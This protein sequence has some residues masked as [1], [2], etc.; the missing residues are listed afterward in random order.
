[1]SLDELSHHVAGARVELDAAYRAASTERAVEHLSRCAFHLR[2]ARPA[3]GSAESI[4]IAWIKAFAPLHARS[5]AA[6]PH[7]LAPAAEPSPP[8]HNTVTWPA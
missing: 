6:S 1:M 2:A 7:A 4:Q 5:F 8:L 3:D